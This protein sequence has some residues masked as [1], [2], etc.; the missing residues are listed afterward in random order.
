MFEGLFVGDMVDGCSANLGSDRPRS[1][2]TM[3]TLNF[4]AV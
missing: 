1:L 3:V 4:G 2:S